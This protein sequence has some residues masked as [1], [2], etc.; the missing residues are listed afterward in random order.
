[1]ALYNGSGHDQNTGAYTA[2]AEASGTAYVAKG[3]TMSGVVQ[4]T[5]TTNHVSH[6][7][8]T[9]DPSWAA[10]TITAT[11]CMIYDETATLPVAD[12]SCYIGDFGGSRSSSAGAFT[13]TLPAAAYN[14]SVIR[15]A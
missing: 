13:V 8:W 2:T 1:M 15:L 12:P 5:D 3:A 11:D 14:T 6:F 10:S 7:D 9:S 4:A